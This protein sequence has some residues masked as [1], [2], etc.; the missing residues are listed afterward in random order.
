MNR[1]HTQQVCG[2]FLM[3]LFGSYL[4]NDSRSK[5]PLQTCYYLMFTTASGNIDAIDE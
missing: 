1:N 3:S 4:C 2:T 5:E